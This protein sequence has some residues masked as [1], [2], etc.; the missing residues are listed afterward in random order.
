LARLAG[1]RGKVEAG[2]VF[3]LRWGT[4][5]GVAWRCRD[6]FSPPQG[7]GLLRALFLG[8]SALRLMSACFTADAPKRLKIDVTKLPIYTIICALYHEAPV[9]LRLD[10]PARRHR[11]AAARPS[12]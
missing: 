6:G 1:A 7:E 10:C 5:G 3:V 12:P 11:T 2:G 4:G 9:R 8:A